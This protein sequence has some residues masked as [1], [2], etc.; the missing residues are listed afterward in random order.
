MLTN[1]IHY[2]ELLI[3]VREHIRS[4]QIKAALSVNSAVIHLYWNIGE[5]I[6]NNQELFEGRNNYIEQLAAD[7]RL[8]FP[9]LP[10][11]SKRNLFELG[12]NPTAHHVNMNGNRRLNT[13]YYKIKKGRLFRDAL[14]LYT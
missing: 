3:A 11:F 9:D 8:E 6:A 13:F 5:M 7:I 2:R 4:S 12:T 1:E 10:G 14:H